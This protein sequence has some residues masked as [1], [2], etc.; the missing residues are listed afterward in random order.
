V[1]VASG[2]SV[3]DG[4]VHVPHPPAPAHVCAPRHTFHG[5]VMLHCCVAPLFVAVQSHAPLDAMHCL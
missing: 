3:S 2:S 1:N 4:G 5:V